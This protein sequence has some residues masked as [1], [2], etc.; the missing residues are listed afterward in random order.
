M[1]LR[2]SHP[3][4]LTNSQIKESRDTLNFEGSASVSQYVAISVKNHELSNKN[5]ESHIAGIV[6]ED[7]PLGII[8]Q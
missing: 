1:S 4:E 3:H 8:P 2:K 7:L 5:K 6:D